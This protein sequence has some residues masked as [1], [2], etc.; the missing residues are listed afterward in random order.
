MAAAVRNGQE[1][2]TGPT[3]T[4]RAPEVLGPAILLKLTA[5]PAVAG[6]HEYS[7]AAFGAPATPANFSG[8]IVAG[9]PADGCAA[10]TNAAAMAGK[11]AVLRRGTCGFVVKAK[12]A[13]DA[14][15]SGVIIAN[16]VPGASAIGLGGVDPTVTVP[17]IG[18]STALGDALITPSG[19]AGGLVVSATQLAGA[20]ASGRVRLF[21]PNPVQPGSS[22]SHFDVV[23]EPSLLMEPAITPAL[24]AS[25]NVDL[26][27]ALFQDI[28]WA[29]EFTLVNCGAGSGAPAVDVEGNMYVAPIF[30][31]AIDARNKGQF[32]SCST[33]YLNELK[34]AG[35]ISGATKGTLTS[36][37]AKSK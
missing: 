10:L 13:Q 8:T 28:G 5:P 20:D 30:Y 32:Q 3:V 26:T 12:N 14:G 9:V 22:I 16:N 19:G 7:T 2:W 1:V 27:A 21:A 11:I 34:S 36:C 24:E 17:T 6:E 18:V 35:V 29:T 25:N 33:H 15:A 4:A 37:A 23:A 31:C